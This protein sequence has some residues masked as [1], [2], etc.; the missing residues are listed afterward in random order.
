MNSIIRRMTKNAYRK[1]KFQTICFTAFIAISVMLFAVSVMLFSNLSGAIDGLMDRAMCTDF[2]QMHAGEVDFD[3]INEFAESRDD[4]KEYQV[5][6]FLNLDNNTFYIRGQSLSEST[7]DN[8]LCIQNEKF[9]Y[10]LDLEN[11]IPYPKRGTI[12]LPVFYKNQLSVNVGDRVSIFGYELTV[13]GFI[14]DSQMNSAMASSKR[15]LV[16]EEDYKRLK[17]LGSEEYLI[18]FLLNGKEDSD[19]TSFQTDYE[20]A[21]L[22]SNGPTITKP[23]IRL[24]NVLSD[25][26]MIMIILLVSFVVL[27][28]SLISMRLMLLTKVESERREIGTLKAIGISAADIRQLYLKRYSGLVAA[29]TV[30]GITVA[31]IIFIPLSA[32]MKLLY[33]TSG[34]Y[35]ASAV[36]TAL[37]A[38]VI[39]VLIM[40]FVKAVLRKTNRMTAMNA[41]RG[42]DDSSNIKQRS[43]GIAAVVALGIVLMIIP[44]NIYNTLAS[45]KFVTYMGIGDAD[46]RIDIR[47]T[48]NMSKRGQELGKSLAADEKVEDYAI[49][50]TASVKARLENGEQT[51]ILVESGDH[52]RFQV[53]YAQG[54]APHKAKEISLS[55]LLADSLHLSVGDNLQ[56][57]L[58]GEDEEYTVTGIYSDI[59]NG[60]KTSKIY[61]DMGAGEVMWC[62][63]YVTLKPGTDGDSWLEAYNQEGME[64]RNISAYVQ[65]T[66]G[67]TISQIKLASMLVKAVAVAIIMLMATLFLML[68]IQRDKMPISI[69]KALGFQNADI[70]KSYRLGILRNCGI[71]IGIGLLLG[72]VTGNQ[73]CKMALKRMGAVGFRFVYNLPQLFIVIPI[74]AV[75]TSIISAR[76]GTQEVKNIGAVYCLRGRE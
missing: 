36:Y 30:I 35:A 52:S 29:G 28:I 41:L 11:E 58:N 65:S 63:A 17:G 48:D 49:Y 69:K 54:R 20:D 37:G 7:Q 10:L 51:N 33:G 12:Y 55:Y 5:V 62:I 18:E 3:K 57:K 1:D 67:P 24:M 71:G 42:T 70:Q 21:G 25:G 22:P 32:Q 23:L 64:A 40:L 66:Y 75:V 16:N 61:G 26:I 38:A 74:V 2:L 43:F 9:D 15:F 46:Y 39:G 73:I 60:G 4:V 56:L 72:N 13:T 6:R 47:Q 19:V 31:Y 53:S 59:T 27:V 34:N 76:L 50:E 14:R 8:G 45:D 68:Q 44:V